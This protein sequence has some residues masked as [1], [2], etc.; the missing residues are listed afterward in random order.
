MAA[1][2]GETSVGGAAGVGREPAS[3]AADR[4]AASK[5]SFEL[6]ES[7]AAK[8]PGFKKIYEPWKKFREQQYEWFAIAELAFESLAQPGK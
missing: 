4:W 7:E 1:A 2:S 6:Y 3:V 5:A 8:N